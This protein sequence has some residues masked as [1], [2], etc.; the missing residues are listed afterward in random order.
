MSDYL[1]L[2]CGF[3]MTIYKLRNIEYQSNIL[4]YPWLDLKETEH[5]TQYP[6]CFKTV[7]PKLFPQGPP[8]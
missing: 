2:Y 3:K 6:I 4:K 8:F 5:K 7:V 1:Y